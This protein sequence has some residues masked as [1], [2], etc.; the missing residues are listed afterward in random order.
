MS[1]PDLTTNSVEE[2]SSASVFLWKAAI[3]TIDFHPAITAN[4]LLRCKRALNDTKVGIKFRKIS[5]SNICQSCGNPWSLGNYKLE[6]RKTFKAEKI[7]QITKKSKSQKKMNSFNKHIL[8]RFL[9]RKSNL[10]I[11]CN[12]C[13]KPTAF[14]TPLAPREPKPVK[15][16]TSQIAHVKNKNCKKDKPPVQH[17]NPGKKHDKQQVSKNAVK[18]CKVTK[19]STKQ[20]FSRSQL[21]NLSKTLTKGSSTKSSLQSFLSSVK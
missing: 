4:L 13:F 21:K 10:I 5:K 6:I 16:T 14:P 3:S 7:K 2:K 20:Q 11:R 8:D 17:V 15:E 19:A 18:A 12:C 1:V 9:E